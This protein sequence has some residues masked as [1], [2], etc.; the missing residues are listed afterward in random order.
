MSVHADPLV[1]IVTPSLNQ[2]RFIRDNIE[3][4]KRQ[5]YQRTEHLIMD[6]GSTDETRDVVTP[7]IDEDR[8]RWYSEPDAGQADA[9]N[10][11]ISRVRGS[12]VGWLNS[13]DAYFD[14]TAIERVVDTF[15]TS[16]DLDVCYGHVA[17]IDECNELL[18][19]KSV[20]RF[21][22][23]RLLRGCFLEQPGVFVRRRAL[24]GESPLEIDLAYAMDYE[25]WLRLSH[26]HEFRLINCV[27]A[28]DRT[29]PT[30]KMVLGAAP[31]ASESAAVARG[32]GFQANRR[33]S[34]FRA[35]DHCVLGIGRRIRGLQLALMICTGRIPAAVR[36]RCGNSLFVRQLSAWNPRRLGMQGQRDAT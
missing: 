18:M 8:L 20:A 22:R 33:E 11:G 15:R 1:S 16:P 25:L 23:T 27:I 30:R 13:D 29:H 4:V 19:V 24:E 26:K 35:A 5:T 9:V 28:A 14:E 6:G 12:I 34:L 32:A 21:S 3:S 17:Y 31:M 10:R 2:G 36:V 7:Y